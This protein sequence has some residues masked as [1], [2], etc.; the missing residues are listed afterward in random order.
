MYDA[1]SV[2]PTRRRH[3]PSVLEGRCGEDTLLP[4]DAPPPVLPPLGMG[5]GISMKC[6]SQPAMRSTCLPSLATCERGTHTVQGSGHVSAAVFR[7]FTYRLNPSRMLPTVPFSA[8]TKHINN[9]T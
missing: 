2:T 5:G 3:A 4:L 8:F 1:G 7:I 6:R 9:V